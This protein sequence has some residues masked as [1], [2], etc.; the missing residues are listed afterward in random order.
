MPARLANNP[1]LRRYVSCIES[2]LY[3]KRLLFVLHMK[4]SLNSS[5]NHNKKRQPLVVIV[6]ITQGLTYLAYIPSSTH[7]CIVPLAWFTSEI[8]ALFRPN[9]I[10]IAVVAAP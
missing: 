5:L 1:Q 10:H 7:T 8:Y 2:N 4:L 9:V 6:R 3:T